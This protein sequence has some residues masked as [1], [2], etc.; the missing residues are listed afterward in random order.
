MAPATDPYTKASFG[1]NSGNTIPAVGL[2]TW[3]SADSQTREAVK[4]ALQNGYR[5]I[6]TALNYGNEKEVGEGIRASGV[7]REDIWVTTKLDNPWHHR[8]RQ[9]LESSL[10]D[11][12][13]GYV[14][15]FLIHFPCST[16]PN[17]SSRHLPDWD[18][19][20]TWQEMQKLLDAGKVRNIGVSNFQI[21]HLEKLLGDP[22]CKIIPAVNQ[23][24]LHP[25]NPSRLLDYCNSKGIH[26]TAYS[27]LGGHTKSPWN[28]HLD[29]VE[30]PTVLKVAEQRNKTPAQILLKWGLQRGTSVIP[31]SVTPARID[32]NFDLDGWSLTDEEHAEI[33]GIKTRAKV[34]GDSWMPIKV[35]F[36]DDE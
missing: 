24:E 6:D 17:D 33:S 30:N 32:S 21:R 14:D 2:G 15:L 18:Y 36:G 19:V 25:Y 9:G 27:C 29:L 22:S 26:C 10:S 5:H 1:L 11:L 7:P 34:V 8:A 16:D 20:K 28:N 4:H 23:L 3:Q 13:I 35:F 31:K 12:G